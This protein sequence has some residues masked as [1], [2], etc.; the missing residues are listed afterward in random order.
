MEY[1]ETESFCKEY[2][3]TPFIGSMSEQPYFT[4]QAFNIIRGTRN[5]YEARRQQ[6]M[7]QRMD[8]QANRSNQDQT[9]RKR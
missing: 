7:K 3:C 8:A 6:E 5:G 9:T 4:V 1:L 2:G